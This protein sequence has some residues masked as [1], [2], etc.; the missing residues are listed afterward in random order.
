MTTPED[1]EI[2]RAVRRIMV[3]HWIDLGR[4]AVRTSNARVSIHGKLQRVEGMKEPLLGP[5]VDGIFDELR[6][7]RSVRNVNARFDNWINDSGRW[8][9][10]EQ[11]DDARPAPTSMHKGRGRR[12]VK[13][14][15]LR[16][17]ADTSP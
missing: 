16:A 4:I 14:R 15:G 11:H 2:N 3:K 1:L 10:A 5:A 9:P 6:R 12:P 7:L 17:D 8:R 13:R